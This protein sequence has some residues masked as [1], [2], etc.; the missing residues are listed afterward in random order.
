MGYRTR[1]R[2]QR[3]SRGQQRTQMRGRTQTQQGGR[4]R[5]RSRSQRGGVHH[6]DP[7]PVQ[8]TA[9]RVSGKPY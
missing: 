8:T 3:R 2:T 1:T 7:Q 6:R 4:R 5:N 9:P